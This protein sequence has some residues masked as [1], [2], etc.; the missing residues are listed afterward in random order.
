M[1]YDLDSG[2]V[3]ALAAA[4]LFGASI[5]FAKLLSGEMDPAW[6][7]GLLYLGSGTALA[8][9]Y[10]IRRLS[11][12]ATSGREARIVRADLPVLAGAILAGGIVAPLLFVTG[13]HSTSGAS[14]ALLLNFEN[15]FTALLA[16]F[17]FREHVDRRIAMGMAAIVAAGALLAW[18]AP[19]AAR[20]D[21]WGALAVVG[22]CLGWAIDNNLT[23]RISGR[24]PLQI[25]AIKSL[26][27]GCVNVG[28]GLFHNAATP[29]YPGIAGALAVGA[30]GYGLSILLYVLALRRIGAART[31]AYFALAPFVGAG[32]AI[33]LLREH[34]AVLFWPATA[35]MALGV[36]LHLNE[37]HEHHHQ[38]ESLTHDHSHRH[39]E[40]HQH[41]HD[42]PWDGHEPHTHRHDHPPMSHSHRHYPDIHHRHR[43]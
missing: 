6:L 33:L 37:R 21:A 12:G 30:A 41:V 31:G 40:H 29:P 2:I 17:V 13:L 42:F 9:Y 1:P 28:V 39:D 15:V 5:P 24:D 36:W 18:P 25:G 35:L 4:L 3:N 20:D 10:V 14:T 43:H 16:W 7:A 32:A 23:A 26:V 11:S 34:P 38:H 22:A 8:G 19:G 27:A